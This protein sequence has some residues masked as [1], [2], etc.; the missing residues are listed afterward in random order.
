MRLSEDYVLAK[1][2]Q[3]ELGAVRNLNLWGNGISDISVRFVACRVAAASGGA[4]HSGVACMEREAPT[5]PLAW[6]DAC[7]VLRAG[8]GA[9]A[10]PGSAVAVG[11]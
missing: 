2:R 10:Q 11:Q 4:R 5:S 8:C 3:A 6:F 7:G 9:Y 1:T